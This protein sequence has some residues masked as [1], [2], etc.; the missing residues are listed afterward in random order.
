MKNDLSSHNLSVIGSK[1]SY[2]PKWCKLNNDDDDDD[3]DDDDSL[4]C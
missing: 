4:L 2:A 1:Q 3:D